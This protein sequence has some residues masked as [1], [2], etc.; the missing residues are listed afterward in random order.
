[1]R[2]AMKIIIL[3]LFPISRHSVT[4]LLTG[5]CSLRNTSRPPSTLGQLANP[6]QSKIFFNSWDSL[7]GGS[8]SSCSTTR[9]FPTFSSGNSLP[10]HSQ[11]KFYI[12]LEKE[13]S[14]D[15]DFIIERFISTFLAVD[16]FSFVPSPPPCPPPLKY[17]AM[18]V[19]FGVFISTLWLSVFRN[20]T[21]RAMSWLL[22]TLTV[23][24]SSPS[25][26][27]HCQF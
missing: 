6:F 18:F 14:S 20:S 8:Y 7:S 25:L 9:S 12:F 21:V 13:E 4:F 17:Q 26:W 24:F 22:L 1:M 11:W 23:I 3:I 5:H 10:L 15:I 27:M 16:L 2:N 19:R